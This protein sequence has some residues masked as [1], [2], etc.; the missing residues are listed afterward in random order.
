[1]EAVVEFKQLAYKHPVLNPWIHHL[2][3][4]ILISFLEIISNNYEQYLLLLIFS[5]SY[6]HEGFNAVV[7]SFPN[8][9][10]EVLLLHLIWI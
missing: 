10:M 9:D 2:I 3:F 7:F 6:E 8:N 5:I 1:M 4:F